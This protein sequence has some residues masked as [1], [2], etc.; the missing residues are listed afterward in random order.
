[1]DEWTDGWMDECG[2]DNDD[3]SYKEQPSTSL[4]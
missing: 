1:M 2:D 3:R 4:D